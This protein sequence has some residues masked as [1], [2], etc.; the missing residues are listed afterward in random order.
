MKAMASVVG[1]AFGISLLAIPARA[2]DT[3]AAQRDLG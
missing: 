2:E 3:P 1:M